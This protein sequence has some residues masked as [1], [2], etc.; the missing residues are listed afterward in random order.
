MS[1]ACIVG[2]Q[3]GDEGKGKVID[4]LTENFDI[5]VRY[6]GGANAGHT[7]IVD[8]G[9][10]IMHLIPSGILH[11][12][13]CCVIG[14]GVV[15]DP[16]QLLFEIDELEKMNVKVSGNL[17]VSDRAHV[18]FPYHKAVDKA[19]EESKGKDKI[20]TTGRGIGPCYVD[21]VARSGIRMGE[22]Y[23]ESY[24]RETLKRN[25]EEKN[26]V[27]VKLFDS[28]P[29]SYDDIYAQYAGFAGKL[30]PY[31]CD[32]VELINNAIKDGKKILLEG[33]QGSLLDVDFGT[34]P[35]TTSSNATVCGA[36][37]GV[38]IPPRQ[39]HRVL[40]IMKAYTTRVGSGPFPT[41]MDDTL[42]KEI[43]EKGCEFGATTG[44][45]RRCGWF[46]AVAVK[47]AVTV[48][49]AEAG[50]VTKLDVLDEQKSLKVCVRYK[51]NGKTYNKF[52]VCIEELSQCEPVYEEF[53]GWMEDTT[54]VSSRSKLPKRAIEY[55]DA[56]AKLVGVKV[57]LVSV[58]PDRKQIFE[59]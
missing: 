57:E 29:L 45:P 18:V 7:V 17:F 46:D 48:N 53:P 1:N 14:N 33:A 50:I 40:G 20:G 5:I 6:Q 8:G 59:Y 30:R 39:I 26:R 31:I 13:K 41:E 3:W 19:S 32:T 42:G 34:Y 35:F 58:G 11:S 2:L 36:P 49:G 37:S 55:V 21:K 54:N 43:Q 44:R 56:I 9:T 51:C 38:G 22:L 23:H 28:K 10:F 47:H 16:E 15:I 25:V 12:D 52:P 24:F 4:V 27:L